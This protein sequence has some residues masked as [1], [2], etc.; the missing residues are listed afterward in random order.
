MLGKGCV[1]FGIIYKLVLHRFG[2][3]AVFNRVILDIVFPRVIIW[4]AEKRV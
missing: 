2:N 4:G 3:N 1:K